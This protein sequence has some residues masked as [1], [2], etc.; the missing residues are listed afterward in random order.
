[1][2]DYKEAKD[3]LDIRIFRRYPSEYDAVIHADGNRYGARTL[4]YSLSGLSL[5]VDGSPEMGR[6]SI[7]NVKVDELE[8][9]QKGR[10][11]WV[12]K[13]SS[14]TNVGLV[15]IGVLNGLFHHYRISDI[16]IGL[17]RSLLTGILHIEVGDVYKKV[18]IRDGN[19]IA[20]WSNQSEDQLGEVLLRE[21]IIDHDK[22][23]EAGEI[24][25][26]IGA[27]YASIVVEMG[28]LKPNEVKNAL[29]LQSRRIIESLFRYRDGRFRFVEGKFADE[30]DVRLKISAANL[31]FNEIK[32]TADVGMVSKYLSDA[33][34]DF[35]HAPLDL[36]QNIKFSKEDRNM[37]SYIDGKTRVSEI[38]KV[39]SGDDSET[40]KSIY[41]LLEARIIRIR[42][43]GEKQ[44][45]ISSADVLS[46]DKIS[47]E[48]MIERIVD[49]HSKYM[50][51]GYYG[52]LDIKESA[53]YD[54]I[55]KAYFK[56]SREFHPDLHFELDEDVKNKLTEVFSYITNAYLT[57]IDPIARKKYD[58]CNKEYEFIQCAD[59]EQDRV[60]KNSELARSKYDEGMALYRNRNYDKASQLFATAIYFDNT[61]AEYHHG[62]GSSLRMLGR[63]RD[64]LSALKGALDLSPRNAVVLTEIGYAFLGLDM[65]KR[66]LSNFSY[67]LK[68][69]PEN[70]NAKMGLEMLKKEK[71]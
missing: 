66:A 32:K 61:V 50:E 37:L 44:S 12:S 38:A 52:V 65:H 40:L 45:I 46:K 30:S 28:V 18:Y 19:M 4:S 7:I 35:S 11:I 3:L 51:L 68:I 1:M 6:G 42:H 62:Y 54:E 31:I 25:K 29:E 69:D 16:F 27:D 43:K 58:D 55:E 60:T 21:K 5:L 53:R 64:A 17:Q 41:A 57:L 67:A 56:V 20:A 13:M 9:D 59:L 36:F 47:S 49:I 26:K 34:V 8:I 23:I 24:E 14:G 33:I 63:L 48:K 39:V 71:G 22:Y 70:K 10:V 15:R 2:R